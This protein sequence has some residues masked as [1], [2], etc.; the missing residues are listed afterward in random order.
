MEHNRRESSRI[1]IDGTQQMSLTDP[2]LGD[3]SVLSAATWLMRSSAGF[4]F[5]ALATS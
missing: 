5:K 4:A 3:D 1:D 2:E